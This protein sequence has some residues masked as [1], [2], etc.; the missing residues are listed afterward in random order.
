MDIKRWIIL[1]SII[2]FVFGLYQSTEAKTINSVKVKL[3]RETVNKGYTVQS[4]DKHLLMPVFP[5]QYQK[6]VR[7]SIKRVDEPG[8]FPA[9]MKLASAQYIYKIK[10]N[11]PGF[12]VKPALLVFNFSSDNKL[13]KQA[14]YFDKTKKNWKKLPTEI[15]WRKKRA[16][17]R[18]VFPCAKVALF[19]KVFDEL[20]AV[21]A[22]VLDKRSGDIVYEKNINEV[23]PVASLTKLMTSLVFLE[24]NPGWEKMVIMQESDFVGGA[25][26]WI[27]PGDQTTI[28]DL[29]YAT[30]VA[31][32]NN[33][34][35]ALVR[36]TGLN[37]K[38]FIQLMND[39][40]R[41][42]GLKKTHFVEP[43]GLSR[44]NVSTAKEMAVIARQ[45]FGDF[46][47]L[48]ASTSPSYRL[49]LLNRQLSYQLKSTSEK[50]LN[51]DLYI[52]GS[53]TGWTSEA[54][55]CLVS[56]AKKGFKEILALVMGSQKDK[57]YDEVYSLL[58]KNL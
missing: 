6:S 17:V 57:N 2:V 12:L 31:S 28:R 49:K 33:A 25:T 30:L 50:V 19:E 41:K 35:E 34:A 40:A 23:R 16:L 42:M 58:K 5:G 53:K 15:D 47:I 45:A 13:D 18:T 39:K 29:F 1:L 44:E 38:D 52:T 48:K 14:Y 32:R 37:R 36:S 11:K 51:K 20:T 10:K 8:P 56:Q 21:S 54:G 4:E 24:N 7:L 43:T 3:D 9:G 26:L 27:D 22:V 46:D 55:Y